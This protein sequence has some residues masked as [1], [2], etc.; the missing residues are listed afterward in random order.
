MI[1]RSAI[2]GAAVVLAA[3]QSGGCGSSSGSQGTAVGA[4]P[5]TVSCT[6]DPVGDDTGLTIT[7]G[8]ITGTMQVACTGGEPDTFDFR[9]ILVRNGVMTKQGANQ[10]ETVVPTADGYPVTRFAEC[11]PGTWHIYYLVTWTKDGTAVH[12]TKTT[13]ADKQVVN[14]DC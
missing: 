12:N 10:A 7:R 4:S 14:S 3:S 2:L 1:T 8:L 11:A 6:E 5:A 9:M 13:T